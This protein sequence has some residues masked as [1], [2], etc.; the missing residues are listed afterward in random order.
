MLSTELKHKRIGDYRAPS[1]I[2]TTAAGGGEVSVLMD[3]NR[4]ESGQAAAE[5]KKGK[6]VAVTGKAIKRRKA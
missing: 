2:E 4:E 3:A 1:A 6:S 5:V